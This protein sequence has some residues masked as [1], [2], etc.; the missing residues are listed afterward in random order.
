MSLIGNNLW[1]ILG[2]ALTLTALYKELTCISCG[3]LSVGLALALGI[4]NVM[5]LEAEQPDDGQ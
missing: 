1:F 2:G 3:I 5:W 4:I